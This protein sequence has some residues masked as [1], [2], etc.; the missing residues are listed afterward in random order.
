MHL[1]DFDVGHF[2]SEGRVTIYQRPNGRRDMGT[3]NLR[4]EE[5]RLGLGTFRHHM[6]K[7]IY[8]QPEALLNTMRGRVRRNEASGNLEVGES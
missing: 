4:L 3:L 5:I 7:E 2:D 6:L 8:E 1:R